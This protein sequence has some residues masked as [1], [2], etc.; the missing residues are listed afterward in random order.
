MYHYVKYWNLFVKIDTFF[1][2]K[3][4]SILTRYIEIK[5]F[6]TQ[7]SVIAHFVRDIDIAGNEAYSFSWNEQIATANVNIIRKILYSSRYAD[8]NIASCSNQINA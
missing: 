2:V 4:V 3:K 6:Y 8:Y 7:T 5:T 1:C